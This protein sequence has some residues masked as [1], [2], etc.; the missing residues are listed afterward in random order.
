MS[1]VIDKDIKTVVI[2]ALHMTEKLE[3]RLNVLETLKVQ[4]PQLNFC[5]IMMSDVRNTLGGSNA[6]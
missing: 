1:Q 5:K 4:K 6:D 3:E 2:A